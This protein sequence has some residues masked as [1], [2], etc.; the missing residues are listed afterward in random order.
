MRLE[1]AG[2]EVKQVVL[3]HAEAKWFFEENM[4]I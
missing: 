2:D 1:I 4:P 3:T